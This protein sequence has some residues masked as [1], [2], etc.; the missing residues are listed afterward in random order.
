MRRL[1]IV[2]LM[3]IAMTPVLLAQPPKRWLHVRVE[4]KDAKG[5]TVRVNVPLSLAEKVLPAIHSKDLQGGKV[6]FNAHHED[7][8]IRAV[9]EAVRAAGDN[10]FVT[11]ESA[12]ENVRVAK[13][14]GYLLVKVQESEGKGE[15]VD[16]KVPFTVVEALLSGEQDELDVLAAVRALSAHGDTE[17]VTVTDE[18]ETVRIWVDSKNALE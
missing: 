16:I 14:G 12:K 4:S 10:E 18:S 15:K 3:T 2:G 5:E 1:L 11:V 9:L 6:K 8:D 17:L 13:A 7:I